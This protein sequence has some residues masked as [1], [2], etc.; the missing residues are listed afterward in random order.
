[1]AALSKE[2]TVGLRLREA[3]LDLLALNSAQ[4]PLRYLSFS[5]PQLTLLRILVSFSRHSSQTCLRFRQCL[6]LMCFT[7]RLVHGPSALGQHMLPRFLLSGALEAQSSR[8][9]RCSL[10]CLPKMKRM[11]LFSWSLP[12]SPT[13]FRIL[14]SANTSFWV[15]GNYHDF[16]DWVGIF[17]ESSL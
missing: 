5:H 14:P 13:C 8:I 9:T 2:C 7:L 16:K 3:S 4:C 1:M 15:P 17:Q 12:L 6:P 11:C 10:P